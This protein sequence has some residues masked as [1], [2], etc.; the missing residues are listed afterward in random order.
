VGFSDY[1]T[2]NKQIN[3]NIE[4]N[5]K[6]RAFALITLHRLYKRKQ[7]LLGSNL[8]GIIQMTDKIVNSMD[9]LYGTVH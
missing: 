7:A 1:F 3:K 9:S 4:E 5:T 8:S 6:F 2:Q